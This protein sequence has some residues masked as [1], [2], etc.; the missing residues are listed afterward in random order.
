MR[1]IKF[2]HPEGGSQ[3]VNRERITSVVYRRL[4]GGRSRLSMDLG[5]KGDAVV[6]FGEEADRVWE[7][8]EGLTEEQ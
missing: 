2:A 8:V 3:A 4:E 7:I 6:L 1:F 5:E